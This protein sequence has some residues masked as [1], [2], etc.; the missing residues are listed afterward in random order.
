M[1]KSGPTLEERLERLAKHFDDGEIPE[2]ARQQETG[3]ALGGG[4]FWKQEE[5]PFMSRYVVYVG[6]LE[7]DKQDWIMLGDPRNQGNIACTTTDHDNPL[8]I[9]EE[10]IAH[11][12]RCNYTCQGQFKGV[13]IEE[14][15]GDGSINDL[16]HKVALAE[17]RKQ[18]WRK[19][20]N[21]FGKEYAL[22]RAQLDEDG[23]YHARAHIQDHEEIREQ[24]DVIDAMGKKLQEMADERRQDLRVAQDSLH[25]LIEVARALSLDDEKVELH[26]V[27]KAVDDLREQLHGAHIADA[28]YIGEQYE[29][30]VPTAVRKI[31][32]DLK[33]IRHLTAAL[34]AAA[35]DAKEMEEEEGWW[36][37]KIETWDL[38]NRALAEMEESDG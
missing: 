16:R 32:R 28:I 6:R 31:A 38:I 19:M 1:R 8:W 11:F 20:A 4:Q 15:Y 18:K 24:Q 36:T 7:E 2:W 10:L 25:G 21:H 30:D 33:R 35:Q 26:D 23:G 14:A 27:V 37:F 3:E 5:F 12:A 29:D 13:W 17:A 34:Q 22:L 9:E